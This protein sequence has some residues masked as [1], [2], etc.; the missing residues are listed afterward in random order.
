MG[1]MFRLVFTDG[2]IGAA[3]G[4]LDEALSHLAKRGLHNWSCI[5]EEEEGSGRSIAIYPSAMRHGSGAAPRPVGT[6]DAPSVSGSGSRTVAGGNNPGSTACAVEIRGRRSR[7]VAV[8]QKLVYVAGP[9]RSATE[10]GVVGNIRA[11]E[12][13]ALSLWTLGFS[14]ICPHKNTA[15][16]GGAQPDAVWL[17][18][19]ITMLLRCD[20]VCTVEGWENSSGTRAEIDAATQHGIP[21]F[22]RAADVL[23]WDAK[24]AFQGGGA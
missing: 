8:D 13:V 11:A 15:F 9:Y 1:S 23:A 6:Y 21:V 10:W 12:A 18:G 22:H 14:V 16:F 5:L 17:K 19:D 4:R 7:V 2:T 20:A 24:R 3:F